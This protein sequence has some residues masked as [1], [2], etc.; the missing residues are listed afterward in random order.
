MN[1]QFWVVVWRGKS[2]EKRSRPDP[3]AT[4]L[5]LE[6]DMIEIVADPERVVSDSILE[7]IAVADGKIEIMGQQD[8]YRLCREYLDDWEAER[9]HRE[10]LRRVR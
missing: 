3:D 5:E 6:S 8:L 4:V 1:R 10:G 2:W 7:V 9:Q